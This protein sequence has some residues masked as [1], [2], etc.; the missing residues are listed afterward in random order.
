[1]ARRKHRS[2][3]LAKS[4][5]DPTRPIPP[6]AE[7]VAKVRSD[8]INRL[9]SEGRLRPEHVDAALEIR[10]VWEAFGRGLF[11]GSQID[12]RVPQP[13]I[14]AMFLDPI[15]RLTPAE[16]IAW[17]QRYRPWARE[18][19]LLIVT[20]TVRVSRL[21]LMLDVVVDNNGI[22]QVE[23]WYRMRHGGAF[24]ASAHEDALD[25]LTMLVQQHS[26]E[27]TRTLASPVSDSTLGELPLKLDL[28]NKVLGFDANGDP[29]A[30][31]GIANAVS[32][33]IATL[34]DDVS[35]GDARA[36]LGIDGASG[37]IASGDL[38]TDAVTS[39]KIAA[40]AVTST[41]IAADAV[42]STE[43][44]SDAVTVAKIAADAV[45]T[46]KV[47]DELFNANRNRVINGDMAVA[48]R[49]T[50]FVSPSNADYLVDR[51]KF[52]KV[53][54]GD[55]TVTQDTDTPT[56]AEAGIKFATSLK[57]DVTTADASLATGDMY[58]ITHPIEGFNI[59]DLGLGGSG[60]AT[61]TAS[62][63]VKATKTGI[64]NVTLRNSAGNRSYP[65]EYSISSSDTWEKKTVTLALDVTGTWL[66]GSSLGLALHFPI[67]LGST[68][69]GTADSWGGGAI[70][71]T[72]LV[73]NMDSASNNM[74]ITGVQLEQGSVATPFEYH[75]FQQELA[76]C[77]RYYC[78]S[79]R[80]ATA[81]AEG[82]GTGYT[83]GAF[84]FTMDG[85]QNPFVNWT[86]PVQMRG[87]PTIA[88]YNPRSGGT[89]GEW[90][91]FT[92]DSANARALLASDTKV[93]IDNT[94]IGLTAAIW[95]IAAT[96]D[97]EL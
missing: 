39:T 97:A 56:I 3:A 80:Y 34:I 9:Y 60:A 70:G 41:E 23:G 47:A 78:K 36:T 18:M 95:Y 76:R 19:A 54:A 84:L 50:S 26:E 83:N 2:I 7:T 25:K 11:P 5:D 45:T 88:L 6:T 53:G 64:Q 96:A 22:R 17:R 66:T 1:M 35:A 77:Q 74:W 75:D 37:N 15:D 69:T 94:G 87:T 43:I 90:S 81:P 61:V 72:S 89:S 48:Q 8:V 93:I 55:I 40:D 46:E 20:G 85:A 31:T 29:I 10:R 30:A 73:N 16:E 12:D 51:W 79:F 62:F 42:T 49:G 68:Y 24:P 71:S 13:H 44:A 63:W 33:Y 91:D 28:A 21:Q 38:A 14:K 86:F 27:L 4:E 67:A 65:A 32:S 59:E 92:N 57:I 52:S 82:L 58:D